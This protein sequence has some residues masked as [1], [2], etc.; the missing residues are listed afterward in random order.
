MAN[1]T[2]PREAAQLRRFSATFSERVPPP[3]GSDESASLEGW[4]MARA[5]VV[6]AVVNAGSEKKL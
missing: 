6:T 3:T 1:K 2:E 5:C 4:I